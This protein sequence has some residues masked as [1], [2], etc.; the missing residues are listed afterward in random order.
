MARSNFDAII[1]MKQQQK[2]AETNETGENLVVPLK[3]TNRKDDLPKR[4]VQET[5]RRTYRVEAGHDKAI[6]AISKL[7]TGET[8]E[9]IVLNIF[10]F[11]FANDQTGKKALK[12]IE[13]MQ[14]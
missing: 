5:L 11:Y 12:I 6:K 8:E 2:E 7:I 3:N 9:E 4:I 13:A 10:R 1:S 14:D